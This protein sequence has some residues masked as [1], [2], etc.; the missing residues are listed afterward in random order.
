MGLLNKS[1]LYIKQFSA[2]DPI[3][4]TVMERLF[5][6]KE[7]KLLDNIHIQMNTDIYNELVRKGYFKRR[8]SDR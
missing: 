8:K 4:R 6:R 7:K 1:E 2:S 5:A 3:I